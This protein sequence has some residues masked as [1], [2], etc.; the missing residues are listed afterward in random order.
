MVEHNNGGAGGG[1][2]VGLIV[3]RGSGG[4]LLFLLLLANQGQSEALEI[5]WSEPEVGQEDEVGERN[6]KKRRCKVWA[7]N[8][9]WKGFIWVRYRT[10]REN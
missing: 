7:L 8:R 4:M 10:E 2:D 6:I 3:V 5:C 9:S 1:G